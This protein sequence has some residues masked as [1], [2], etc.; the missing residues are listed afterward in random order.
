MA[1]LVSRR[2]GDVEWSRDVQEQNE[3]K[4]RRKDEKKKQEMET[5]GLMSELSAMMRD[6][7]GQREVK[8]QRIAKK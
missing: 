3:K 4:R 7:G 1:S 6:A 2:N 5:R 8:K